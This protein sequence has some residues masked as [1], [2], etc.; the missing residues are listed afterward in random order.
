MSAIVTAHTAPTAEDE[1]SL[2]ERLSLLPDLRE[3]E[4]ATAIRL[5]SRGLASLIV[6][7]TGAVKGA[8][9]TEAGSGLLLLRR[10]MRRALRA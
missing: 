4:M 1:W 8:A 2:L 6:D 7:I 3:G 9:L 5:Q 10:A